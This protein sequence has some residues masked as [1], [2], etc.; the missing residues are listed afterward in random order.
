MNKLKSSLPLAFNK[1]FR[2]TVLINDEKKK[3]TKKHP[4]FVLNSSLCRNLLILIARLHNLLMSCIFKRI[5][6]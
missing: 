6:L 4:P 3:K 5:Y 2:L 1:H